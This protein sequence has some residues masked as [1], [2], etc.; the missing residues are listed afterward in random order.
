MKY[1]TLTIILPQDDF[2]LIQKANND[3]CADTLTTY[4][5]MGDRSKESTMDI[6][7]IIET[8]STIDPQLYT[9]NYAYIDGKPLRKDFFVHLSSNYVDYINPDDHK[10]DVNIISV[11]KSENK[12]VNGEL[13]RILIW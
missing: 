3:I 5:T 9:I 11:Q 2:D 8:E 4:I 10:I 7:S 6:E 12:E 13:L 1:P